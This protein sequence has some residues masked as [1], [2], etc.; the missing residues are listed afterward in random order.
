MEYFDFL[1]YQDKHS[2][3]DK[4][5]MIIKYTLLYHQYMLDLPMKVAM[6]EC[7]SGVNRFERSQP[8]YL[9]YANTSIR[10]GDVCYIDYG[11]AYTYEAGFQHFG[12]VLS[13]VQNKVFVVPMTSN[14]QTYIKADPNCDF[15]QSHVFQL[16]IIEGL[17]K[18]SVCFLNDAKF[19]NRARIINVRGHINPQEMLFKKLRKKVFETIFQ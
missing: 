14:K 1:K 17:N 8:Q 3:K 13:I 11:Q 10:V 4:Q 7:L 18:P 9:Q 16:G 19:I 15:P 6:M 5:E 12:V 2:S